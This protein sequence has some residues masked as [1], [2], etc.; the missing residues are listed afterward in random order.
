[1]AKEKI[2]GKVGY[3]IRH[4]LEKPEKERENILKRANFGADP[5]YHL[6]SEGRFPLGITL[7]EVREVKSRLKEGGHELYVTMYSQ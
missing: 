7:E 1:M 3:C 5:E 4:F 6:D 2:N